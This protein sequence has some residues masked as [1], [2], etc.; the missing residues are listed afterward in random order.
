MALLEVK[1]IRMCYHSLKTETE[2]IKDV[3]FDVND[4]DF[5][6]IL[7]PSG[8]GKSTLLKVIMGFLEKSRGKIY[9]SNMDVEELSRKEFAKK[10]A[11]IAQKSSQNL[12]FTVLEVLKLG[13]VPHI[14]N[15][16]KGLDI[17]DEKVVNEIV[18]KLNLQRYL[19]RDIK[20]LSGGEFQR[21]LLGR[22]FIQNSQVI[23]LDEPTSALD[24]NYSLEFLE[25]LKERVK[26]K[27]VVGIIVI[28]DITWPLYFVIKYFLLRMERL[29]FQ[30]LQKRL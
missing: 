26:T 7:G 27:K 23:L 12:N 4:K 1:N 9:L 20:S 16:F 29:Q 22:A 21:V 3:S 25:L 2:A 19:N 24:I 6:S 18:E 14:K 30:E 13:R 5:L 10:V 8:C 11:F 28:H 15:S 17:E